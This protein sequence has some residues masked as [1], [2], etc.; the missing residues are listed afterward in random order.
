[1]NKT[2]SKDQTTRGFRPLPYQTEALET[3]ERL[4]PHLNVSDLI[5]RGLDL[6]IIEEA[7][8]LAR[9]GADKPF[10]TDYEFLKGVDYIFVSLDQN[11][12][13]EECHEI[14]EKY[15]ETHKEMTL[16]G[17]VLLVDLRPAFREPLA[18]VTPKFRAVSIGHTFTPQR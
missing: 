2:T 10:R 8:R 12:S 9:E 11:L 5:H 7:E 16:P 6:A 17:Q 4:N 13:G 15:F 14:A 1:M 3:L 18:D